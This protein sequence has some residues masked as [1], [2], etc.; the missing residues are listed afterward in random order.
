[1]P[2]GNWQ[3]SEAE[4]FCSR[5]QK[6]LLKTDLTI[7]VKGQ[8]RCGVC[9]CQVRLTPHPSEVRYRHARLQ[10]QKVSLGAP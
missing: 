9:N 10:K 7:S 6:Y 3:K 8:L 2:Y 1:M 4:A 5:C